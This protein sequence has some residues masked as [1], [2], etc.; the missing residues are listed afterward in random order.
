[1]CNDEFAEIL[2]YEYSECSLMYS[3]AVVP[4]VK[5]EYPFCC[6]SPTLPVHV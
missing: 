4:T 1:M 2:L 3:T 6:P 5:F